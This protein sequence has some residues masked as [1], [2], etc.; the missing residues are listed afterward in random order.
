[1]TL[2]S[3]TGIAGEKTA[4][5]R[6]DD[7][8]FDC[9][10]EVAG[11]GSAED[12]I[13][14]HEAT[15]AGHGLHAD[16]AVAELAVA[17]GLLLV[18]ALGFSFAA[19]G[20]AVGNLG[21]LERDFSV[22]ALFEAADDG[23]DVRLARAGDEEFVG[24]R[25]AEEAD[26]Q[27]L[28]HE[29]VDG[30]RELVLVGAGL[31]LDGVGHGGLGR[32]GQRDLE[33]CALCSKRVAGERVAELGHC[34]EVAGVE[35]GDFD[36]L[37]ALH[38]AEV[39]RAF[40]R[41]AGVVFQRGVVLDHAADHFEEGDATGERIGHGLEDHGGDGLGVVDLARGRVGIG[42]GRDAGDGRALR[43]SGRVDLQEIEKMIEGHVGEAAGKEHGE[44]AI[45]ADGFVKRG[46]EVIFGDG[47]FLEVLFHQ[48]V[49]AFGNELDESFV[50]GLGVGRERRGNF[51]GGFAA[52]IAADGVGV[53]LHGD[54]I[55]YAVKALGVD[56]G[57]LDGNTV[58]APALGEIVEEGAQTAAATG[59]GMVHLIDEN[60][61]GHIGFFSKFPDALGHRL[62]AGLGVDD[63]D[64][65]FDGKE[66][67]A[68]FVG[69]HVEAGRIDEVD[70]DALPLGKGD[71]VLH[72]DAAGHFLFVIGGSGGA[73][74][75]TAL[76]GSHFRGMQQ[77]GNKGGFAAVCMPHYSY[78][79]DL[80]SLVRFHVFL[81]DLR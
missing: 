53:G 81:L 40:R 42:P 25:V 45:F 69:E 54:E 58:A 70:F 33:F 46:D 15:A 36:G 29:L 79:A 16:F 74:F 56:D 43:S 17:A 35:L 75:D 13:L 20:F 31:G 4:H 28:F 10:D 64:G 7:A 12:V 76:G 62:D 41:S 5:G 48:L 11:N 6:L 51:R 73:V 67:G 34:A 77:S 66:R 71:G 1:M 65:G 9:G 23:L 60:D 63:Y 3:T 8:F 37:A 68:G 49:F 14:E 57:Q 80:T 72:G 27:I 22:V 61:A 26:E 18:P 24:L 39:R 21:R 44:D 78:V 32:H 55:D 38:D 50:A 52:A 2:K 47:A 59:F 30:G 19:D